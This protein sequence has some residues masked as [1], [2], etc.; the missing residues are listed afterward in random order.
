M[1]ILHQPFKV[2]CF[3]IAF[4]C[5]SLLFNGGFLQL[6]QLH[7][8]YR[9]IQEQIVSTENQVV[10]LSRQLAQAKDPSFIER[11][12]LDHYDLASEDDMVFVFSEE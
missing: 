7:Q 9:I 1:R 8:D 5:G 11:Q 10:S 4:V 2:F 12:A 6:Y 3:C